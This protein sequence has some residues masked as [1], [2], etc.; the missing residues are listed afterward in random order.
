MPDTEFAENFK[1]TDNWDIIL[2]DKDGLPIT[3]NILKERR[4]F[5]KEK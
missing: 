3:E 2:L 5:L 4:L 1:V